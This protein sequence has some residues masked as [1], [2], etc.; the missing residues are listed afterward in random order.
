MT[1]TTE[2]TRGVIAITELVREINPNIGTYE[3]HFS[4]E[5]FEFIVRLSN[6]GI[7]IARELARDYEMDAGSIIRKAIEDVAASYWKN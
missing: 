5:N 1:K 6:G 2:Q 4:I 7:K 3:E